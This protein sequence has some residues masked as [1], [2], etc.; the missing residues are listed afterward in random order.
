MALPASSHLA[1]LCWIA[2]MALPAGDAASFFLD[3]P[4][5]LSVM[6]MARNLCYPT[7]LQGVH[8]AQQPANL[9]YAVKISAACFLQAS[10]CVGMRG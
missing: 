4:T 9:Q 5:T 3:A 2:S 1:A 6:Q 10:K 8:G 7:Y